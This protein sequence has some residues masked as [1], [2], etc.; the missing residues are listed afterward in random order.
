MN[1]RLHFFQIWNPTNRKN[2][3]GFNFTQGLSV[4][5]PTCLAARI[6]TVHTSCR[7]ARDPPAKA[8]GVEKEVGPTPRG[9][10][11]LIATLK[12]NH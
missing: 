3:G 6:K 5:T 1:Q 8:S 2:V 9:P 10:C 4:S 7:D 12:I 11:S